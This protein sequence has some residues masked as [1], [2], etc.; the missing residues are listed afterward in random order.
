MDFLRSWRKEILIGLLIF[1]NIFV[2][3]SLYQKK[4]SDILS[5]YFLD[6]GQG[7]A[8]FIE[9]PQH[10]RIL[11]DGG[12]NR[13]VL[14]ELGRILPFADRRIDVVIATHPD[15]DH[16]GGLPEVISRYKV[17]TFIESGVKSENSID[18]ELNMR[19]EEKKIPRLLARRG[20][21]IDLG[22]EVRLNI[23]FPNQD[24]SKLDPN[25]ASIVAK[26]VYGDESFLFTA[27]AE[28]RTET[29]LLNLD[30]ISLD[31]DVLKVGHHGSRTS[32][33][34]LFAEAVSP[35]Y[36]IISAGKDNS[37]GHPHQQVL[38]TLK[39][40]SSEILSTMNEGT[41]IFETNGE[42]LELK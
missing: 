37:Y 13:K 18:D 27:D 24:V 26:L 29:I 2:W 15:A 21:V 16:I 10:N 28:L 39:K 38:D 25:D 17:G 5:V 6:V 20:M 40:V 12:R 4:S 9:S 35:E 34:I 1:S 7:D 31:S 23:L 3:T 11:I 33:F 30:P 42:T 36:A 8:I 32:T 19:I 22:D 41:I 14:S